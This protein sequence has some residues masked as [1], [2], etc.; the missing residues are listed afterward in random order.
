MAE[1]K[2]DILIRA[3]NQ[4]SAQIK[5]VQG[6]LLGLGKSVKTAQGRMAA[7]GASMRTMS[8]QLRGIGIGMS[9]AITAP[10]AL[11]GKAAIKTSTEFEQSMTNAFSVMG[12]VAEE[13]EVKLT[14]FARTLGK[15]TA[16]R[17]SEAADSMY[18]L[19]S[20]GLEAQEIIGTL[21]GVLD[22][23]AA[24]QSD[25]AEVAEQASVALKVYGIA[26]EDA[27][28]ITDSFAAGIANS[29]LNFSRLRESMKFAGPTMAAFGKDI[30]ETTAALAVFA[31]V[32]FF[33]TKAG[34]GLRRM[35]ARLADPTKEMKETF[36]AL[37]IEMDKVNPAT[38]SVAEIFGEL[39][40]KGLGAADA[41]KSFGQ[42]SAPLVL[43][44]LGRANKEG[45]DVVDVFAEF[46][47]VMGKTG[48][49]GE[50][51]AKQLDTVAGQFK[52]LKSS[53]E[54]V[55]IAFKEDVLGDALQGMI[56]SLIP[57]V[58]K[59]G[60]LPPETKKMIV[61]LAGVAAAI[62]PLALVAAGLT[63]AF[64]ALLT[65]I[66]GLI[67]ALAALAAAYIQVTIAQ[68]ALNEEYVA[69]NAEIE[70]K[71]GLFNALSEVEGGF[72]EESAQARQL[73]LEKELELNAALQEKAELEQKL[74]RGRDLQ[75][76]KDIAAVDAR[77]LKLS[78]EKTAAIRNAGEIA[79][80][81][82]KVAGEIFRNDTKFAKLKEKLT[83]DEFKMVNEFFNLRK[84]VA[85][86]INQ[87]ILNGD[88]KLTREKIDLFKEIADRD[89]DFQ[90][91]A[92][93]LTARV[94]QERIAFIEN[95]NIQ[96]SRVQNEILRRRGDASI[97]EIAIFSRMLQTNL[98]QAAEFSKKLDTA[99]A[100]KIQEIF[101]R[102]RRL[103]E[104]GFGKKA[105]GLAQGVGGVFGVDVKQ[106]IDDLSKFADTA[107]KL[108]EKNAIAKAAKEWEDAIS[109][110]GGGGGA[111]AGAGAGA[112]GAGGRS[113]ISD[114]RKNIDGLIDDFKKLE[115][116]LNESRFDFETNTARIETAIKKGLGEEV[117]DEV[118]DTYDELNDILKG[119]ENNVADL[120]K[121]HEDFIQTAKDGLDAYEE[122]LKSINEEF[123]TMASDSIKNAAQSLAEDFG[124]ALIREK[125]LLEELKE[126]K[127]D[128][129]KADVEGKEAAKERVD[130]LQK[131]LDTLKQFKDT[132]NEITAD[133]ADFTEDL[134]AANMEVEELL[135][136]QKELEEA[137]SSTKENAEALVAAQQRATVLLGQQKLAEEGIAAIEEQRTL[138]KAKANLSDAEFQAFLLGKELKAIDDKKQ[139]EIKALNEVKQVQEA[140]AAGKVAELDPTA[141]ETEE[142]Q[143]LAEEAIRDEE[144]FKEGLET[145]LQILNDARDKEVEIFTESRKQIEES[146]LELENAMVASYDRI[147]EKLQQ[148]LVLQARVAA[149]GG[150][151]V[152]AF[153]GGQFAGGGHT[154]SGNIRDVAG[155]V[156]KG[157]WVAPNWMVKNFRPMFGMLENMRRN[158]VKGFA[159]GGEVG[160]NTITN[161]NNTPVTMHNNITNEIDF[162]SVMRSMSFILNTR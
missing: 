156:H 74:G 26:A 115:E 14:A 10:L 158:K 103:G 148:V 32:G 89:E 131:E 133:G 28:R 33:G 116:A 81:R 59:F 66:G 143:K 135:V 21:P 18:K 16:F 45:R 90:L 44:V 145:Q 88:I 20:A 79:D 104:G 139:A 85:D 58:N 57:L 6:D 65:P 111:G 35:L 69:T 75:V 159:E 117:L 138:D 129:S 3:V 63:A 39:Q 82:A 97:Q 132:F 29:N 25:L 137:G 31:D 27:E 1:E 108:A 24:T 48:K 162:N 17:A 68:Q 92:L 78:E 128:L 96:D 160:G 112:G 87:E 95:N 46:E 5:A 9:L 130:D 93:R 107:N 157:E 98:A 67:V 124:T 23:A 43:A 22:L 114:A 109:S 134:A 113:A 141:F 60:E 119:V 7:F 36:K 50:V 34:T 99:L 140:I 152:G 2:I 155:V 15:E 146:Q 122:T 120:T 12:D 144:I 42:I 100:P 55:F 51:A 161:T 49:A 61:G 8:T 52:I 118:I 73:A 47:D 151:S 11:I 110:F 86:K 41:F 84:G 126:A 77:I 150:V 123:D 37:G 101:I 136:K 102:V 54:E 30:E 40:K 19:A 70:K 147:I 38:N 72:F 127:D 71:I 105:T 94:A 64:A 154:G 149:G 83:A 153:S 4:A 56:E 80:N 106:G 62:G 91:A 125:E 13:T 121:V 142:A 76:K 53:I